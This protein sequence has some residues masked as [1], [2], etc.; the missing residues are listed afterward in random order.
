MSAQPEGPGSR[1]DPAGPSGQLAPRAAGGGAPA[2]EVNRASTPAHRRRVTWARAGP[3][4]SPGLRAGGCGGRS[5]P[6]REAR[7]RVRVGA[8]RPVGNAPSSQRRGRAAGRGAPRAPPR[9]VGHGPLWGGWRGPRGAPGVPRSWQEG[10]LR[11]APAEGGGGGAAQPG[12]AQVGG[13][14]NSG[15]AGAHLRP[16]SCGSRAASPSLPFPRF[17]PAKRARS[18]RVTDPEHLGEHTPD[19]QRQRARLS[20]SV[21]H[22]RLPEHS[23]AGR[24]GSWKTFAP[25]EMESGFVVLKRTQLLNTTKKHGKSRRGSECLLRMSEK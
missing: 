8:E 21:R 20:S 9:R 23:I 3:R 24:L 16:R 1:A 17:L 13:G 18:P 2:A 7:G 12:P 15:A 6:W 22:R 19:S 14:G 5:T 11:A 10:A 25:V 4:A